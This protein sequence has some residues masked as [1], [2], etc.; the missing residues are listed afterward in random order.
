MIPRMAVVIHRLGVGSYVKGVFTEGSP[1]TESIK[2]SVQPATSHDLQSLPEGRRNVKAYRLYTS[3]RLR[4]VTDS[5]PDRVELYGE[6]YEVN[7][8]GVWQNKIINHYKYIV[9]KIGE[10]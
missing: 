8:E 6:T 5:N 3:T 1:S 4:M 7:Y 10:P 2:A 9:T